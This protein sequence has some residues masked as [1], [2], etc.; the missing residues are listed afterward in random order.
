[1]G[2]TGWL[3]LAVIL[4]ILGVGSLFLEGIS[5][6]T[7]ETVLEAGPLEVTAEQEERVALPIWASVVL[8]GG[9]I[10]AL[11]VGMRGKAAG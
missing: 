11:V 6:A 3:A 4:L 2:R 9:G 1:M 8:M 5:Y 7:Q 10:V